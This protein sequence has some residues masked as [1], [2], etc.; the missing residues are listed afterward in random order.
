MTKAQ[1]LP[2]GWS[3]MVTHTGRL[4]DAM[5]SCGLLDRDIEQVNAESDRYVHS[6]NTHL[7]RPLAFTVPNTLKGLGWASNLDLATTRKGRKALLKASDFDASD[8]LDPFTAESLWPTLDGGVSLSPLFPVGL[9]AELVQ[10]TLNRVIDPAPEG[11]ETKEKALARFLAGKRR[12]L[13][14]FQL[15]M[16]CGTNPQNAFI[17]TPLHTKDGAHIPVTLLFAALRAKPMLLNRPGL[18][19]RMWVALKKD[20][21]RPLLRPDRESLQALHDARVQM[22]DSSSAAL[23]A[24]TFRAVST[25]IRSAL[26]DFAETADHLPATAEG[27]VV[28][29]VRR[30]LTPADMEMFVGQVCD[31]LHKDMVRRKL[32]GL[33]GVLRAMVVDI[34]SRRFRKHVVL[35]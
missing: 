23:R 6:G 9:K 35:R 8:E 19:R 7:S 17:P 13:H 31:R 5:S 33:D 24:Q 2:R 25:A 18:I 15:I 1:A 3:D 34:L 16:V 4:P 28:R 32:M 27:Y 20:D 12:F 22:R 30:T 21:C 10:R 26:R 11:K 14:R 29:L